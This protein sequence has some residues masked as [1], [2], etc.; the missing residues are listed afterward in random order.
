MNND[1]ARV[2]RRVYRMFL[3][4]Y[5]TTTIAR[6]LTEEKIPSPGGQP[7]WHGSVVSSI[8]Q[9]EKY[10]GDALLQKLLPLIS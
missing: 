4:G 9:N 3:Q 6:K 2:V 7:Q 8:L 1:E 10:K 5:G